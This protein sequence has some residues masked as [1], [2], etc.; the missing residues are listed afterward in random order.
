ME[1]NVCIKVDSELFK[2][3]KIKIANEG[4]TMKEYVLRLIAQ[5]L[6]KER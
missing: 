4:I 6:E 2:R 5:D 1:R 3:I